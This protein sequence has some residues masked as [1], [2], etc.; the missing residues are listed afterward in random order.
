MRF[1]T[2]LFILV[3]LAFGAAPLT[4]AQEQGTGPGLGEQGIKNYLLGPGD[5][6]DIRVFGQPDFNTVA[7]IDSEGNLSSL[8]F[9][10]KPIPARCR[11]EKEVSKDIIAVYSKYLKN[12][13]VSVRVT[14]RFSRS[15]ATVFGAVHAPTQVQMKRKAHL[16]ELIALSGGF[17]ERANGKIQIVHTEPVM[18]PEPGEVVPPQPVEGLGTTF[19]VI[20]IAALKSGKDEAN[21]LI[22]P[23]D[24][25]TVLEAEPVYI[26]GSVI[27][28]QGIFLR[29]QLTLSRAIAMV[30]GLRKEARADEVRIYRKKEGAEEEII[31]VD[32]AAIKKRKIPDVKLEPFDVIEVPEAGVFSSRRIG[33]TLAQSVLGMVGSTFSTASQVLQY[34]V[35]Y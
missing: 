15:P 35:I 34:R 26:T 9:T 2:F 25:I 24:I 28:P 33:Q 5:Q 20:T 19:Q 1:K 13:Q 29:D 8:P 10:E 27:S 18:C 21:P 31:K 14:G 16:T 12:P 17:T 32:Y 22:R 3:L 11:N 7:E 30:G 6:L 4:S 23:G